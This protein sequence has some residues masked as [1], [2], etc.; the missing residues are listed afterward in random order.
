MQQLKSLTETLREALFARADDL[1]GGGD[2]DEEDDEEDWMEWDGWKGMKKG[3]EDWMVRQRFGKKC[4][5]V[6]KRE[7]NT[8]Y[9]FSPSPLASFAKFVHKKFG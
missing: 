9:S 3:E 4:G 8:R 7:R 1:L 2:S 6:K 5:R